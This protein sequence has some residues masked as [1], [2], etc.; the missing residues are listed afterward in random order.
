MLAASA[1]VLAGPMFSSR[2]IECFIGARPEADFAR[3]LAA[4]CALY[5]GEAA[6]TFV[7]VRCACALGEEVVASLRRD[8]FRALLTQRVRFFDEHKAAELAALLSVELGTVR[9]LLVA[10]AS[11]DRGFRAACEVRRSSRARAPVPV[12]VTT[13]AFARCTP[14]R[15]KNLHFISFHH[16]AHLSA[17]PPL[18]SIPTRAPLTP[19]NARTLDPPS[20]ASARCSC[21]SPSRPSWRPCSRSR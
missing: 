14:F 5:A 13:A 15:E 1:V 9:T 10:N 8:L 11:R 19:L 7:Y 20:S 4:L 16:S 18:V 2:I 17:R 12:T 3:S 21:C 6:C